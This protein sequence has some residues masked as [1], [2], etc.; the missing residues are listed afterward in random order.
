M[1]A[2]EV[3]KSASY[4]TGSTVMYSS[5]SKLYLA[6]S[7]FVVLLSDLY[8]VLG[9]A[10]EGIPSIFYRVSTV[11]PNSD[12]TKVGANLH[13]YHP[14]S[15]HNRSM[16]TNDAGPKFFTIPCGILLNHILY[17]PRHLEV[18]NAF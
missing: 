12:I 9:G 1:A 4:R 18:R 14:R 8:E 2:K 11:L 6:S 3:L 7:R 16:P 10:R 13:R 5:R 15:F 17:I